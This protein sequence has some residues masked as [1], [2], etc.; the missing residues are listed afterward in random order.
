MKEKTARAV[1]IFRLI[2]SFSIALCAIC[3]MCACVSIYRSGDAPYSRAAVAAAFS[4]ISVVVYSCLGLTLLNFILTLAL[5]Q[6]EEKPRRSKDLRS[7]LT[8]L[9]NTR[10]LDA[11]EG[12]SR[13]ILAQ[14]RERKKQH[15]ICIAAL[16]VLSVAFL[17]YALDG[18]HFHD[19]DINGSMVK[20]MYRLI[21][22]LLLAFAAI[23]GT[24][25][26][27]EKSIL[28]EIELLKQLPKAETVPAQRAQDLEKCTNIARLCFLALGVGLVIVGATSGGI[29]DV[30][31]KAINICTECIG[32]G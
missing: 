29:A 10:D 14:R 24:A 28:A 16:T 5:P 19:S 2:H 1:R 9:R 30:L 3:L 25:T 11:D 21:P 18:S 27:R 20:A 12:I 31:A 32:L 26:H 4:Q 23:Y 6:E 15:L 22:C 13:Q 8:R 17:I 7:T